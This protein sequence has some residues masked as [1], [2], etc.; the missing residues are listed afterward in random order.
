MELSLSKQ[1]VLMKEI[2][3]THYVIS[4]FYQL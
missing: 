3:L 1:S 2:Y 4:S